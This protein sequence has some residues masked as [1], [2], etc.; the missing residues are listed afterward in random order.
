MGEGVQALGGSLGAG[1]G[2]RKGTEVQGWTGSG[3]EVVCRRGEG[4]GSEGMWV[5]E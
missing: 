4:L 2:L 5:W 1:S 3:R